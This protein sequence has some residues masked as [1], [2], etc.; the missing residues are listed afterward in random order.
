MRYR[1]PRT[2]SSKRNSNWRP[3]RKQGKST[4]LITLALVPLGLLGL[5]YVACDR[6]PEL[7]R[8]ESAE[9]E[10]FGVE[11]T[12]P[13]D[14]E[15]RPM[16]ASDTSASP[17]GVVGPDGVPYDP[18]RT[19][20]AR[21]TYGWRPM[22]FMPIFMPMPM[23]SVPTYRPIYR[24]DYTGPRYGSSYTRV[25]R[26]TP[27]SGYRP[28]LSYSSGGY[29]RSSGGSSSSSSHSSYSSGTSR[30]GFGSTSSSHS[31]SSSSGS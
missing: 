22:G 19:Y 7:Q 14:P 1:L 15:I 6:D 25:Y 8:V 26:P 24:P 11:R 17:T 13:G 12:E 3:P 10:D 20:E 18:H 29:T 23:W 30:G 31:S 9:D 27:S 16:L 2:M 5:G 28:S 21:P 4:A